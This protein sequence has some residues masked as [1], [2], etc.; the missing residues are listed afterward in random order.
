MSISTSKSASPLSRSLYPRLEKVP[1]IY[2]RHKPNSSSLLYPNSIS[3]LFHGS[4][5]SQQSISTFRHIRVTKVSTL[6]SSPC[7]SIYPLI[8]KKRAFYSKKIN[9]QFKIQERRIEE[10]LKKTIGAYR[11]INVQKGVS[12]KSLIETKDG[13]QKV[14]LDTVQKNSNAD[15][16]STDISMLEKIGKISKKPFYYLSLLGSIIGVWEFFVPKEEINNID[17]SPEVLSSLKG[18]IQIQSFN[19]LNDAFKAQESTIQKVAIIGTAGSGKTTL[20]KQYVK[21]YEKKMKSQTNT[22]RTVFFG[23]MKNIET[24]RYSYRKFAENLVGDLPLD[25]QES[26]VIS[27]VNKKLANR[28]NWLFVIDNVDPIN[29]ESLQTFFPDSSKGKILLIA[30]EELN[31]IMSFN[32]QKNSISE[33]E[34]LE[35]F[36]LNLGKDHWAFKQAN[37][38]KREL[39]RQVSYLPL[40][41]KQAAIHFKYTQQAN[42]FDPLV[43]S[44]LAQLE[45]FTKKPEK[46]HI[47]NFFID[48]LKF[49]KVD[50]KDL[51]AIDVNQ[52]LKG[53]YSLNIQECKRIQ[54]KGE[55]CMFVISFFNPYFINESI[56]RLWF[57]EKGKSDVFRSTLDLFENYSLIVRDGQGGWKVHPF[58][59][60]VL[61]EKA[62]EKGEP[63]KKILTEFLY[64]LKK[65]YKLDM[66]FTNGY[67]PKQDL[68]NHLESLIEFAEKYNLKDELKPCF[69]HLYNVVGNYHVQSNNFFEARQAFKKSLQIAGVELE[70]LSF[71]KICKFPERHIE[72]PALCAQAFHYLGRVHFHA[73]ELSQ[74]KEHFEIALDIQRNLLADIVLRKIVGEMTLRKGMGKI[75]QRKLANDSLQKKTLLDIILKKELGDLAQR[76]VLGDIALKKVLSNIDLARNPNPFDIIIFQRQGLGWLLLEGNEQQV[77]EAEKLYLNLFKEKEIVGEKE[78]RDEFNEGYC[79]L[80]LGKVYLKLAQISSEKYKKND[81]YRKALER[82]EVGNKENGFKGAVEMVQRD[83]IKAG[84]IFLSLGQLYLDIGC[85]SDAHKKQQ[86]CFEQA[87]NYLEQA[88][89]YSKT[90]WRISAKSK[91]YL[92]KLYLEKNSPAE[93]FVAITESLYYY[94]KLGKGLTRIPPKEAQEAKQLKE[95]IVKRMLQNDKFI[96]YLIAYA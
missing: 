12:G 38:S 36:Q 87:K 28:P 10:I 43:D 91:H 92:T 72:L 73:G 45:S 55:D 95:E 25:A 3:T 90:D 62:E 24:F 27:E 56:L 79:N 17:L 52:L 23:D 6:E 49:V 96:N 11:L 81:Y 18:L 9:R 54:P 93:A 58:L 8:I 53:I 4:C 39:L 71:E 30:Q 13:L 51:T 2:T 15:R 64:F 63:P 16:K 50:K 37:T 41:I 5:I 75:T 22:T 42:S 46:T 94:N 47:L 32:I 82:L 89:K 85:N 29:Y 76:K 65:N 80:Q 77:L 88:L 69:V 14:D 57:K 67:N 78:T 26:K 66:R 68:L 61:R 34:A 33:E 60:E 21:D 84:E 59:Q 1:S 74:A 7:R 48:M 19:G 44:Y 40:A 31:G 70:D 86:E 35:I 20:A 83:H